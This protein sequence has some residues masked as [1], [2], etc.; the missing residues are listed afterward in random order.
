VTPPRTRA[1]STTKSSASKKT[2]KSSSASAKKTTPRR[3]ASAPSA[4]ARPRAQAADVARH[5][6]E[7]L[8]QLI[9]KAPGEVTQ[10]ERSDD[11]WSIHVEVLELRRIPDTMDMMALYE[12][13]TDD[14]GSLE[15]YRRLRRYVRGMP[16]E[17]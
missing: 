14:S 4:A 8:A 17:E 12:V 5:A 13:E 11:G 9:R 10:L 15:G 7:Q 3:S 1:G 2:T 16:G 6:A